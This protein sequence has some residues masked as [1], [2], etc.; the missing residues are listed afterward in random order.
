MGSDSVHV[1]SV[2]GLTETRRLS[3]KAWTRTML[4]HFPITLTFGFFGGRLNDRWTASPLLLAVLSILLGLVLLALFIVIYGLIFRQLVRRELKLLGIA[5]FG[6]KWYALNRLQ[7]DERL[8]R[9]K[10]L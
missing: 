7:V 2:L 4:V 8:R 6:G 9:V 3:R 10:I 5:V 1:S